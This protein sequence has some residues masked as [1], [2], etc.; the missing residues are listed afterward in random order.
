[1]FRT[2]KTKNMAWDETKMTAFEIC[3]NAKPMP[4]WISRELL[5]EKRKG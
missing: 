5:C 3:I 2:E 1:M 4:G